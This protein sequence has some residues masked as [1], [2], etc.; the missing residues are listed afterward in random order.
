MIATLTILTVVEVL[1]NL[2]EVWC[3]VSQ[4]RNYK[5]SR[6]G[7]LYS[8]LSAIGILSCI[9][10]TSQQLP[11]PRLVGHLLCSSCC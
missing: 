4:M 10:L 2:S 9:H 7:R 8:Y 3:K 6:H 1:E 5:T 11:T